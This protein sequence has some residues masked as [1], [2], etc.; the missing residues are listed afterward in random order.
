[1][2][3]KFITY[4]VILLFAFLAPNINAESYLKAINGGPGF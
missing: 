4:N 3:M 2:N 1:M